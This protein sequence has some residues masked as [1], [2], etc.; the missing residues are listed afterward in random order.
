MV[1]VETKLDANTTKRMNKRGLKNLMWVIIAFSALFVL[2]GI[3]DVSVGDMFGIY[4]IV[5]GVLF[6]PFV[7][8]FTKLFQ[9]MLNKSANFLSE[10]TEEV[11]TFDEEFFQLEQTKT[12]MFK[13]TLQ[14][15]YTYLFKV[16]EEADVWFMYISNTQAHVVPKKDI[17]EGSVEELNKIFATKLH[18]KFKGLAK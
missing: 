15:N 8:M 11:Y 1:K 4:F 2:L 5:M 6:Y 10:T 9:K 18:D 14:A 16:V 3:V 17:K 12:G 7:W 13:S